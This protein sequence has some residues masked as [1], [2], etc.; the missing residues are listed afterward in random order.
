MT[1][2]KLIVR[3][4]NGQDRQFISLTKTTDDGRSFILHWMGANLGMKKPETYLISW[5]SGSPAL[6]SSP[7]K[8]SKTDEAEKKRLD[9]FDVTL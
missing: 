6:L 4:A 8:S 5:K 3:D 9:R 7:V 1:K 2:Y